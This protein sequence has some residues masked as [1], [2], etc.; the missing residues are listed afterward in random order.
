MRKTLWL[1]LLLPILAQA[2]APQQRADYILVNKSEHRLVVMS[3][4]EQLASFDA[5]F[6][7]HPI[8]HKERQ[9]DQSW[10]QK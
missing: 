1:L 2:Q 9:G 4:G 10:S 3:K 6:G 8:G 7:L 5:G